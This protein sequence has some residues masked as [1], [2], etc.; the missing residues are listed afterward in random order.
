[1]TGEGTTNH[2]P[3]RSCRGDLLALHVHEHAKRGHVKLVKD[4]VPVDEQLGDPGKFD[5]KIDGEGSYDAT[6]TDAGDGDS[7]SATVPNGNVDLSETAGTDTEPE[8]LH[9]ELPVRERRAGGAGHGDG[10]VIEDLAVTAG[11]PLDL[12]AA[13]ER[14]KGRL[15][16]SSTSSRS[17]TRAVRPLDRWSAGLTT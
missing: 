17:P 3:R 15:S 8:R 12:H 11:R 16:S 2:R 14:K 7:V 4:I 1:M 5:L 6:K 13:N 10:T 9:H